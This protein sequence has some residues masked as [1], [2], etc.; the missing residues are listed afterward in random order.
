M[1]SRQ[2]NLVKPI[3]VGCAGWS[4]SSKVAE[5]FP[6]E[7]SHLER[8]ARVFPSVEINSSFYRAH[9]PKTYA[10]WAASVPDAF[11]FSVKVPRTVTH[12][13][14][15]READA[16]M[17]AFIEEASSLGHK[18]GRLLL[19]LPP[20]LALKI[21]IAEP[22]FTMLRGLT[23]VPVVCEPRHASWFTPEAEQIMRNAG[24]ACVRADPQ[25]VPGAEPA[26]DP[27]TLYIRLHGS[28]HMYYSAYDEAYIDAVATRIAET[29]RSGQQVWC[30][31]DN[32]AAGEAIP[33]ALALMQRLMAMGELSA[34]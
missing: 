8:Y 5:H 20:S 12:E 31:F 10:R 13:L 15:L 34:P 19:Q 21:P 16:A 7:G 30:I 4:L 3:L 17:H 27:H 14:R 11:R 28:P 32:T 23:S 29:R 25:P 1:D 9:L 22:F 26:G 2:E 18:L 24:V 6:G 33:N